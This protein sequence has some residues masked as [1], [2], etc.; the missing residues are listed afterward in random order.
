MAPLPP[1]QPA[2]NQVQIP[3]HNPQQQINVQAAIEEARRRDERWMQQIRNAWR[4][5]QRAQEQV[6]Q[7]E[8]QEECQR[9]DEQRD[10][11]QRQ[12]RLENT[13]NNTS[14]QDIEHYQTQFQINA[15]SS[16]NPPSP[17]PP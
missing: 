12:L 1:L 14:R 15:N 17:S 9:W 16:R 13:T 5:E 11:L 10:L 4:N 3:L 8:E 6:Q 2:N 7:D